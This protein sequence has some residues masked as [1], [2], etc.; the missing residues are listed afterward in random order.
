M[1]SLWTL[2]KATVT[3]IV[4]DERKKYRGFGKGHTGKAVERIKRKTNLTVEECKSLI[5]RYMGWI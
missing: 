3:K 1:N 4:E 2:H 5:N